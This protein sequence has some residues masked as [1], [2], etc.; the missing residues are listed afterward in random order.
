MKFSLKGIIAISGKPGLYKVIAQGNQN[1]IVESL[2]DR[3]RTPAYSSSK[4]SALDEITM[5][6]TGEEDKPLPEIVQAIYEKENGGKCVD[7][8]DEANHRAYFKQIVPDF[9]EEKVYGSDIKK[10]FGWYSLML[11]SGEL[12]RIAEEAA[13]AETETEAETKEE[14]KDAKPEKKTK[15]VTKEAEPEKEVKKEKTEKAPAKKPAAK[16]KAK[17]E[18]KPKVKGESKAKASAVRKAGGQRGS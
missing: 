15:A 6:T 17:A 7:A 10:L 18:P 14:V 1:V 16:A 13:K 3:K 4:I 2:I 9:D 12:K 11:S 5:Y 8:K